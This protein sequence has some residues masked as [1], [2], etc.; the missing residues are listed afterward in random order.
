MEKGPIIIYGGTSMISKE[1]LVLMC[2][3]FNKFIIFCRNKDQV[4]QYIS[5]INLEKLE[6]KIFEVD[7]LDL[8]KNISIIEKFEKNISGVIWI[9]GFTGNPDEEFSDPNKIMKNFSLTIKKLKR[10]KYGP[11][12]LGSLK[13]GS[14][15]K[16]LSL[17]L[18]IIVGSLVPTS[19]ILLLTISKD[20]LIADS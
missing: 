8:D 1:L 19:S 12:A 3:D 16:I 9:S 11:L 17:P 6:I 18:L 20:C 10:I 14:S 7:L 15:I 4:N 2:K 5:E 13:P